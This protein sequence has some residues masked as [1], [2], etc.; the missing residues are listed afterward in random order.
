[1]DGYVIQEGAIPKALA[2]FMQLALETTPGKEEP[3][4]D[5][6]ERIRHKFVRAGS[7]LLGP[8]LQRGAMDNT[9]VYL[10]M[11]HDSEFCPR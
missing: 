1:L 5:L 8:Y 9:Q 4:E 7:F 11:S 2:G 10:V 6:L 3:D